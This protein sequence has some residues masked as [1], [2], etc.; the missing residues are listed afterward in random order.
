MRLFAL[1]SAKSQG[2]VA[3]TGLLSS[4]LLLS[5]CNRDEEALLGR[6]VPIKPSLVLSGRPVNGRLFTIG[7]VMPPRNAPWVE[8]A[9]AGMEAAAAD[10]EVRLAWPPAVAGDESERQQAQ[11]LQAAKV[12]ALLAWTLDPATSAVVVRAA[13]TARLPVFTL[14]SAPE[15]VIPTAQ[16][17][18]ATPDVGLTPEQ[19]GRM[20]IGRIAAYLRGEKL[21]PWIVIRP[22][23]H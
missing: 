12:N 22:E 8:A 23:S 3:V 16:F 7:I 9:R 10:N 13:Q 20:A 21:K 11:Q 14:G 4:A 1:K 6:A 17:V 19:I 5:G 15:H 18:V 2:M